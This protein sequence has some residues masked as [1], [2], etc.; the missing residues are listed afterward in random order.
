M[1][2]SLQQLNARRRERGESPLQIGIGVHSGPVVVGDIGPEQRREYTAIGDTV[3]V[4]SRIEGLTKQQGVQVLVS[5]ATRQLAQDRF[6]WRD[7]PTLPVQGKEAP[8]ATFV[9][10]RPAIA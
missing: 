9:P 1:V 7:A 5:A 8:I 4:A 2:S 3:N 6:L 10:L